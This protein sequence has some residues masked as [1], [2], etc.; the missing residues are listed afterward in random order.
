MFIK[1][2]RN[3]DIL[4]FEGDCM[5]AIDELKEKLKNRNDVPKK[6]IPIPKNE[7]VF[8]DYKQDHVIGDFVKDGEEE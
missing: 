1:S 5:K 3:D 8:R 4:L 7:T 6:F 2:V